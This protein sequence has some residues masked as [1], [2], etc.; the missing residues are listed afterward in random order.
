MGRNAV[1]IA[2]LLT[3]ALD[4]NFMTKAVKLHWAT[5]KISTLPRSNLLRAFGVL[6]MY[7]LWCIPGANQDSGFK[8]AS[9][10]FLSFSMAAM[11]VVESKISQKVDFRLYLSPMEQWSDLRA[12]S[13]YKDFKSCGPWTSLPSLKPLL[14][15]LNDAKFYYQESACSSAE[16]FIIKYFIK[17]LKGESYLDR[18]GMQ[19]S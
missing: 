16:G 6:V 12:N 7:S 8:S 2:Y 18:R 19:L 14:D 11:L 3:F 1:T 13:S 17:L 15:F 10:C 4:C 5:T 9:K